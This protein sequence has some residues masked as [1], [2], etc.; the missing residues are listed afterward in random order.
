[1]QSSMKDLG[2]L[3]LKAMEDLLAGSRKIIWTREDSDTSYGFIARR[4]KATELQQTGQA[5]AR[6]GEAVSGEGH[7]HQQRN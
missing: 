2:N 1:M 4:F 5:Q 7:H 3:T 6:R